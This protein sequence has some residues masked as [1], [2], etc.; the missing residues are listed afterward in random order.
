MMT[1]DKKESAAA[2]FNLY[3]FNEPNIN[4]KNDIIDKALKDRRDKIIH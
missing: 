3:E 4:K 2:L 1:S